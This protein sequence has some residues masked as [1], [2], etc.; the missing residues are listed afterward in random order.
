MLNLGAQTVIYPTR[1]IMFYQL[2]LVF[3]KIL[4]AIAYFAMFEISKRFQT[5]S[6]LLILK[7]SFDFISTSKAFFN[8]TAHSEIRMVS[9]C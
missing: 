2:L 9:D 3:S 1:G 4:K 7:L 8:W 5:V 6:I